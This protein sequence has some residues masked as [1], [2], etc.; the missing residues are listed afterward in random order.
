M[1]AVQ[2]ASCVANLLFAVWIEPLKLRRFFL[3]L[4]SFWATALDELD[5]CADP[6]RPRRLGALR[7]QKRHPTT[8][9]VLLRSEGAPRTEASR[10][11][12]GRG[13]PPGRGRYGASGGRVSGRPRAVPAG[14]SVH[15]RAPRGPSGHARSLP[16]EES[17]R[18]FC[19]SSV[20]SR[21]FA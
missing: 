8:Q 2:N 19:G 15:K 13:Y 11:H 16:L 1:H 6:A 20:Q 3:C 18:L 17:G 4:L 21:A 12:D 10:L 14:L 5:L 7:G 9:Q